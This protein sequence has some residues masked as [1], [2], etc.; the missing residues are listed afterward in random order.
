MEIKE[1][2]NLSGIYF[3]FKNPETGQVE[4]RTFEDLPEEKQ[5]KILKTASV[6]WLQNICLDLARTLR[7][8]A[9]QFDIVTEI[10]DDG[11]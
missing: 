8:I 1:K 2:R 10:E 6:E 11:N 4:N 3:R 7:E 5:K 9:D